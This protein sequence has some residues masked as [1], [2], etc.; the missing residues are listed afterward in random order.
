VLLQRLVKRRREAYPLAY[1][2][3]LLVTLGFAVAV[4]VED[5][6]DPAVFMS[7]LPLVLILAQIFYPTVLGW[8]ALWVP[9]LAGAVAIAAAEPGHHLLDAAL[10][11]APALC[12]LWF[13]PRIRQAP[14][15]LRFVAAVIVATIVAIIA[16]VFAMGSLQGIKWNQRKT[17]YERDA[18]RR[19]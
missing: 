15:H 16:G 1:L 4:I 11:F 5:R 2:P 14:S 18:G 7:L 9:A 19:A 17:A 12:V 3:W 6:R 10:L 8:A 13:P